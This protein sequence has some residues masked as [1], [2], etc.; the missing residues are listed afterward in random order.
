M[1]MI[2]TTTSSSINVKAEN[3]LPLQRVREMPISSS[4]KHS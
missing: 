3:R 2:A 4:L 1:A